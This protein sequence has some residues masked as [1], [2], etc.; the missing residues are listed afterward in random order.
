MITRGSIT[1]MHPGYTP[2]QDL[3]SLPKVDSTAMGKFGVHFGT[4]IV[5][6]QIIANNAFDNGYLTLDIEGQQQV[7]LPYDNVLTES[8]YYLHVRSRPGRYPVVPSFEDWEFP[9]DRIP[10]SWPE[11]DDSPTQSS[12]AITSYSIGVEMAH[13]VEKT[14]LSWYIRNQM[15]RYGYGVRDINNQANLVPLRVDI[16]RAFY[17]RCWA[18]VP[19]RESGADG[20]VT[21]VSHFLMPDAAELWNDH[22]NIRGSSLTMLS[23]PYIFARFAWALFLGVKPFILGAQERVI[24]RVEVKDGQFKR[25]EQTL[26]GAELEKL[27]GGGGSLAATPK[28][29]SR[30]RRSTGNALEEEMANDSEEGMTNDSEEE[31]DFEQIHSLWIPTG[32]ENAGQDVMGEWARREG[33]SRPQAKLSMRV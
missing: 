31:M 18:I 28:S 12:C 24:V 15:S 21:Y 8:Q 33:S 5:A 30:K 13:F 14:Q 20:R 17:R 19:K 4:A 10:A 22:H 32:D 3:F 9:H 27:Y 2:P 7:S 1:F 29:G 23:R 6:C 25:V 26:S 16:H 11:I